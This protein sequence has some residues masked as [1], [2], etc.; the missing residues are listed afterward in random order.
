MPI[1]FARWLTPDDITPYTPIMASASASDANTP[2]SH[3]AIR[4]RPSERPSRSSSERASYDGSSGSARTAARTAGNKPER[5]AGG[6]HHRENR[7]RRAL[8]E[9][10][11]YGAARRRVERVVMHGS[12]DADDLAPRLLA[13]AI[14]R[15]TLTDRVPA[16]PVLRDGR[17]I[18]DRHAS[19]ASR[20][21]EG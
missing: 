20:S 9:R 14:G 11:V 6:V 7:R 16:A 12:N 1:S 8:C 17:F 4:R 3:V 13:A 21:L 15:Q 18:D 2:M 19:P 10:Q 5:V